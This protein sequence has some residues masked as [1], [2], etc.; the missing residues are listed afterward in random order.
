MRWVA[1]GPLGQVGPGIP[2]GYRGKGLTA[3][4]RALELA[5]SEGWAKH[6]LKVRIV[7]QA[8]NKKADHMG[9]GGR[10]YKIRDRLVGLVD[11]SE[12][13]FRC[14]ARNFDRGQKR[15]RNLI[16]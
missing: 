11:R 8:A 9:G 13:G 16:T 10:R 4:E 7:Q 12:R 14:N 15:F 5:G 6:R 3:R 2:N 1:P